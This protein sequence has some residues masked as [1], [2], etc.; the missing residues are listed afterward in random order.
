MHKLLVRVAFAAVFVAAVTSSSFAQQSDSVLAPSRIVG[1][2]IDETTGIGI[3]D[4]IVQVVGTNPVIGARTGV[5]GRYML[6]GVPAATVTLTIRRIGYQGKEV[7]GIWVDPGK[8]FEQNIALASAAFQGLATV[9]VTAEAEKGTVAEALNTQR[10][11]VGVV[12]STT[13]E[14]IAKSPD[15]N[16]A[17]AVGRISGI[18]IDNNSAV[19]ARGLGDKYTQALLN[20]ARIPSPEPETRVVPLDLFPSGLLQ[21]ITTSKTFTPD[22]QGDFAGAIVDIKTREFPAERLWAIQLGQGYSSG[23]TGSRL[24]SARMAGGERFGMGTGNRALPDLLK[25]LGNFEGLTLTQGDQ[26]QVVSS[27]RN[28]WTPTS[29]LAIPNASGS[30]SFGGNDPLLFGHRVGYLISGTFSSNTDIKEH[31]VRALANR[32]SVRGEAVEVDRFVGQTVSQGVLWGGLL[33]A[34]T[35]IGSGTRVSLNGMYNRTADNDAR[36]E[37]GSFEVTGSDVQITRMQYVERAMHSLQLGGEHQLGRQKL[38]W[39]MTANGVTRDEPDRSAFIQNIERDTPDGPEVLRWMQNGGAIRTF[40]ALNEQSKEARANYEFT[41]GGDARQHSLKIGGLYRKT[42]RDANTREYSIY[43]A[44]VDQAS[45]ELP[46]EQLFDGRFS[47]PTD[48]LFNVAPLSL[49]GSYTASDRLAT[50]YAMGTVALSDRI[51]VIAGA[52]FEHDNPIVNA[53]STFATNVVI[54]KKW[55][56]VL[57]SLTVNV[58]LTEN[59]QLRLAGSRTLA[60]P[61]YRELTPI[62]TREVLNGEVMVGN[63]R[64]RR[65]RITNADLR[66]EWYGGSSELLSIAVFAKKFDAPIERVYRPEAQGNT[67][68]FI[69][70]DG[71]DNYGAEIE[72]RHELGGF[73]EQLAPFSV[74]SNLT[75]MH[76]EI[77]LADDAEFS[78]TNLTRAMVG[79][80]PYVIN[81]GLTYTSSGGR[82]TATILYNRVGDRIEAAGESPLPDVVRQARDGLDFSLRFPIVGSW[83]GRFDAKNLLDA[84]VRVTQGAVTREEFKLG[85]VIQAGVVWKP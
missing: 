14:Q 62:G 10:T 80:A 74:F 16:A 22:L 53:A 81:G 23:A 33:N 48:S 71:A 3:A 26:N 8:A 30:I 18:N 25:Y 63:D 83:A 70:A 15:G 82:T 6:R 19:T 7:T 27:F 65:T 51:R 44:R 57:P 41:F 79:Q 42:D 17:Q 21:S 56:D 13:A 43:S 72:W 45:R 4:V 39:A 49:G 46:A 77:R 85:R 31:Q 76:S 32:G 34:S 54:E 75:L 61:E 67:V 29:A 20:G 69:N 28:A 12:N 68:T 2:V 38:D 78:A 5:D 24:M 55:D 52:R 1:R 36:V 11:A 50:A 60:R 9:V 35:M 37:R 84:P 40:S 64:L 66:W 47:T 73:S 59:Q 58:Q